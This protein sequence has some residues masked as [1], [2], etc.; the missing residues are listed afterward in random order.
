MTYISTQH[1]AFRP[2]THRTLSLG[3][4]L[5]TWRSRQQLKK[6]DDTALADIGLSRTDALNEAKRPIWDVP[7]T[8]RD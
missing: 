6:L 4:I 7:A 5:D 8:W 3:R 2:R 1:T